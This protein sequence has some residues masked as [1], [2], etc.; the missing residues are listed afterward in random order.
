[1]MKSY[2]KYLILVV[3]V[4]II[5]V[6]FY[7]KVYIPK[8]TFEIITPSKGNIPFEI[9][10]IGNVGA[11]NIYKIGALYGGKMYDFN[12]QAG[13]KVEINQTIAK[14]DSVD[15]INQIKSQN[16][17][18]EKLK[19]DIKA[20]Q[21][22]KKS[23]EVNYQY[24]LDLFKKNARLYKL[25]SISNLEYEK[26]KTQKDTAK[27]KISTLEANIKA[28]N[29]QILQT[30]EN[31]KGLQ[32]RFKFYTIISPVS[33]YVT[34]KIAVNHQILPPNSIIIEVVNPKDVWVQTYIDTRISGDVKIGDEAIIKLR[35]SN[36]RY[37]GKVV[38]IN[39]VN[40]PITYEREIDVKFDN[41]VIPFYMSEQARVWIKIKNLKNIIKIP[42]KAIVFYQEKEGVWVVKNNKVFFKHIKIV[43]RYK[44]EAGV[45]GLNIDDK[46]VIPNLKK[47]PLKNGMKIYND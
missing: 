14:I 38:N 17:L 3:V 34:K 7:K 5:G 2:I 23:A 40:N 22:D 26:Y 46:I 6:G 19:E 47:A 39:P 27:L 21:S 31:I 24:Q 13:D 32:K 28:L 20:L 30:E 42:A 15:L 25:H 43:T 33:G 36:K 11:E 45:R 4:S 18:I 41:L 35:S 12:I 1:M 8:H 37:K 9:S 44:N 29:K 10:G 16:A